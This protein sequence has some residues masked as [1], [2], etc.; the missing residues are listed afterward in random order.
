MITVPS[1]STATVEKLLKKSSFMTFNFKQ[2]NVPKMSKWVQKKL[3]GKAKKA[4]S[5]IYLRGLEWRL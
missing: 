2:G 5:L 1:D 3:K 4:K